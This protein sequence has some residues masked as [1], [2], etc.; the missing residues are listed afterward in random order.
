VSTPE[1]PDAPSPEERQR[2]VALLDRYAQAPT[3]ECA[4]IRDEVLRTRLYERY[5]RL[6]LPDAQREPVAFIER[7]L[8]IA[9]ICDGYPDPRDHYLAV[10]YRGSFAHEHGID[11]PAL[12]DPIAAR[13]SA[14]V[15]LLMHGRLNQTLW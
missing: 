9:S 14:R 2:L 15:Q 4:R 8:L 6:A 11:L 5:A 7:V 13:S 12:R 3:D 1:A 10:E